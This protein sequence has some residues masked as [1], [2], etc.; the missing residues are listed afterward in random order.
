MRKK[1]PKKPKFFLIWQ[2]KTDAHSAILPAPKPDLPSH[3]FS[4][5]PPEEYVPTPRE[6]HFLENKHYSER[7]KI[8][9]TKYDR[10]RH[11]PQ[12]KHLYRDAFNRCLDLYLCPRQKKIKKVEHSSEFIKEMKLPRPSELKPY[13]QVIGV[14]YAGHTAHIRSLHVHPA[15]PDWLISGSEDGSARVWEVST[16]RCLREYKLGGHVIAVQWNPKSDFAFFAAVAGPRVYLISPGLRSPEKEEEIRAFFDELVAR[17]KLKEDS[18]RK[19]TKF[20]RWLRGTPEEEAQGIFIKILHRNPLKWFTWHQKGDY[21]SAVQ[22]DTQKHAIVVHQL[23]HLASQSPFKKTKG[24]VEGVL[25][26]PTK[27]YFFVASLRGVR[28]YNLVKQVLIKKMSSNIQWIS[29]MDVHPSGD[30][31]LIAGYDRRVAWFDLDL[32]SRPYKT[33]RYHKYAVR[34]VV[35]HP[36]YPLFASCSDDTS[37][38]VFHGAVSS[39]LLENATIVPLKVLKGHEI[40]DE[41]GVLAITFHPTQPWLFS[42]GA[43]GTI[44]LWINL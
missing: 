20:T 21:F 34:G 28:V 30:H 33:M 8:I 7:P 40:N 10:L 3:R 13:P 41:L 2:N 1:K 38:H 26:H 17:G 35:Y 25:F 19:S 32:S 22:Q 23:T 44:K 27:P 11:V 4:Y 24:R 15:F 37:V 9:P 18:P 6:R 5:N 36:K 16:G 29:A 12:Y 39:S 43:D 14:E 42:A 31:L